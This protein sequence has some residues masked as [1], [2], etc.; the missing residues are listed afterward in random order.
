MSSL[1]LHLQLGEPQE[2]PTETT[3]WLICRPPFSDDI[4]PLQQ[5]AR[6]F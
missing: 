4:T 3:D 6:N 5:P 2:S 1:E